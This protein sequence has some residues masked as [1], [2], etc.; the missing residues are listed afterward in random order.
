MSNSESTML[1]AGVDSPGTH[2]ICQRCFQMAVI[3]L[4]LNLTVTDRLRTSEL[5]GGLSFTVDI[6]PNE[7]LYF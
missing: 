3:R 5:K 4:S 2:C 7:F 6:S 1:S